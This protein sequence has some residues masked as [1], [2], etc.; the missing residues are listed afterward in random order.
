LDVV[1]S[2][3]S[4]PTAFRLAQL[5]R[6]DGGCKG[7]LD[8]RSVQSPNSAALSSSC[9]FAMDSLTARFYRGAAGS[10][11]IGSARCFSTRGL[12]TFRES[13]RGRKKGG[14]GGMG[15]EGKQTEW[16]AVGGVV[17]GPSLSVTLKPTQ[18][19]AGPRLPG[20]KKKNK[21]W[22]TCKEGARD[23]GEKRSSSTPISIPSSSRAFSRASL[24]ARSPSCPATARV[25]LLTAVDSDIRRT[26][27][28]AAFVVPPAHHRRRN[29]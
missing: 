9:E 11:L 17:A 26:R 23:N 15:R 29:L 22:R 13:G 6:G 27:S 12:R 4:A 25:S 18:S 28:K 7:P 16:G 8:Y 19:R 14:K 21:T 2:A 5:A 10:T 1:R 20:I 24:N 3:G